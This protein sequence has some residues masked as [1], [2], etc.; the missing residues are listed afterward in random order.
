MLEHGTEKSR[1]AEVLGI[2]DVA[3][4]S[5]PRRI[6]D[7]EALDC[8]AFFVEAR[9][10]RFGL[11]GSYTNIVEA[12]K[13]CCAVG[14]A[15]FAF[16][17]ALVSTPDTTETLARLAVVTVAIVLASAGFFTIAEVIA[18]FARDAGAAICAKR[19]ADP[20]SGTLRSGNAGQA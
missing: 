13:S 20:R 7:A 16:L 12:V 17:T 8:F 6:W 18:L 5:S 15:C 3:A 1:G 9:T 14:I 4:L 10:L 11:T 2:T 19:E